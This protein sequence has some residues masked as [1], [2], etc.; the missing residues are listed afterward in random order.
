MN[1]DSGKVNRPQLIQLTN[2]EKYKAYQVTG[3]AGMI[4][5]QHISTKEAVVII[6]EGKADLEINNSI[7]HLKM[8]DVFVI[9][10]G[11]HHS[12]AIKD[13]FKSIVIMENDSEIK[14]VK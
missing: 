3:Y 6:Q 7:N 2:G 11:V 9:P 8:N 1:L 4:M 13:R 12:L 14:F 10:A 5:P